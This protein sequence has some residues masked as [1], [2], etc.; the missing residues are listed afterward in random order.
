MRTWV[1]LWSADPLRLGEAI[2]L[3]DGHVDGFHLDVIDGQAAPELLHGPSL[4]RSIRSAVRSSLLDVHL[5]TAESDPW[6]DLYAEIGA[7]LITIHRLASPDLSKALCRIESHGVKPGFALG[8]HEPLHSAVEVLEQVDRILVMATEIGVKGATLHEST[9]G[10]VRKL[11]AMRDQSERKPEIVVDGGIRDTTVPLLAAAGADGVVPGSLV[12][13]QADWWEQL[14]H[15]HGLM[16]PDG[17]V[18]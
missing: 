11:V 4:V 13:D 8:L 17:R 1:S 12:F 9:Y 3:L 16:C 10:R 6:L 15:L 2:E 18:A 5:M 7:D 14:A